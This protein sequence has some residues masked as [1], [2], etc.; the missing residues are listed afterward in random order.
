MTKK[1]GERRELP[2]GVFAPALVFAA[3]FTLFLVAID[4]PELIDLGPHLSAA[5]IGV[6][7]MAASFFWFLAAVGLHQKKG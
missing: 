3:S 6:L 5:G 4:D 1:A 2:G 7:G